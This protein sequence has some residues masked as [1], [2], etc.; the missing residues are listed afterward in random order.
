MNASLYQAAAGMKSTA[1]WQEVIAENISS[2]YIPG[3]KR[4]NLSFKA[5]EAGV[6]AG[7][8]TQIPGGNRHFAMPASKV[9]IDFQPGEMRPTQGPTDLAIEGRGFFEVEMPN[10]RK[11]YTRDGEFHI[12]TKGQL[13]TKQGFAVL[14]DNGPIQV[15]PRNAEALSITQQ[16]EVLQGNARKA[17]MRVVDF[18][19]YNV[20]QG[21]G[22]ATFLCKNPDLQ[23]NTVAKPSVQ[24]G[25]VEA[26]NVSTLREMGEMLTTLRFFEANQRVLQAQDER[27]GRM[28][29][30][31]GSPN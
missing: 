7:S 30:E 2:G 3:F 5:V 18:S 6:M 4:Q 25:F 23:P 9:G 14:G 29:S 8:T 13:V 16:G 20:L 31:V 26:A 24:Q 12:D 28:I 1:R 11:A 17:T 27:L 10:G 21:I 19:D 15:D 22:G